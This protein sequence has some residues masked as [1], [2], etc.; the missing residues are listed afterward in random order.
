MKSEV[1]IKYSDKRNQSPSEWLAGE[2]LKKK[3][4]PAERGMFP[5]GWDEVK[6]GQ[7]RGS[8]GEG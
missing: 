5:S 3:K 1:R 7:E 6:R 2:K 4:S 8:G